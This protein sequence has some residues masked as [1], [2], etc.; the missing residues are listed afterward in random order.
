MTLETIQTVTS[1]CLITGTF[2]L[3]IEA[4][5]RERAFRIESAIKKIALGAERIF[6]NVLVSLT[7]PWK[8]VEEPQ[9]LEQPDTNSNDMQCR[10]WP[11]GRLPRWGGPAFLTLAFLSLLIFRLA[12]SRFGEELVTIV[13]VS[14]WFGMMLTSTIVTY[15][16]QAFQRTLKDHT[17]VIN[18]IKLLVLSSTIAVSGL[19]FLATTLITFLSCF[20]A[21]LIFLIYVFIYLLAT[22]LRRII[23]FRVRYNLG[24]ILVLFGLVLSVAGIIFQHLISTG[25]FQ[26]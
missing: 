9:M 2:L 20:P 12:V 19:L 6:S 22:C 1:I 24:N 13:C 23:D 25:I 26:R 15:S 3:A 8:K 14:S 5:G 16:I 11:F 7:A 4:V 18:K 10:S 21:A 17:S